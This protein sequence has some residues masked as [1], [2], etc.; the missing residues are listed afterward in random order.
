VGPAKRAERV[1]QLKLHVPLSEAL[2]AV[3]EF[4]RIA[5]EAAS[6]TSE[7]TDE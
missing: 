6:L 5:S 3:Q 1:N 2:E 7:D 4:D